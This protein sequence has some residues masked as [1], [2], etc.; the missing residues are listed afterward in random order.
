MVTALYSGII[1]SEL[2][3]IISA[4]CI[5]DMSQPAFC[6]SK[7]AACGKMLVAFICAEEMRGKERAMCEKECEEVEIE[8][9]CQN[10]Y[11]VNDI[12]LSQSI[13]CLK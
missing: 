4:A 8:R 10:T 12:T 5:C 1:A 3:P 2:V 6:S 13:P 11:N 9:E 7:F